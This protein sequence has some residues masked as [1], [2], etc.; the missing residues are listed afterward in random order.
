MEKDRSFRSLA[1]VAILIAIVGISVA[2]AALSQ[3]L[4]VNGTTKVKGGSWSV[5]FA[6]LQTPT[7]VGIASIDTAATLT[8]NSTTMNFAVSLT[9]PGD[10]VTYL[11]DVTNTG[12]I[13]SKVSA[14]SLSGVTEA[15]AANV[16]Y[17]LTYADGTAITVGDTLNAG[18]TKNLKLVVTFN[19]TATSVPNTDIT[20]NLGATITY[21]QQ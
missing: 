5:S 18:T 21:T 1:V 20:L 14:V 3:V 9:Q 4:T 8:N 2:F 19:S 6:N 7:S 13:D 17:T 16:T 11:F 10:S 15:Q 12:T